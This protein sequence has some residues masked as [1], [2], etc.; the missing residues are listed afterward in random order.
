MQITKSGMVAVVG[1]PN[2]GKS[3]LTNTLAG[4]KVTIVSPKPQTT[5]N[6]ICAVVNRDGTQFVFMDTPG[7]HKAHSALGE[8]MSRVV[9]ESMDGVDAVALMVE[10]VARID[11]PEEL[12]IERIASTGTPALLMINKIDTV[13]AESL[14]EVI[15][16]YSDAHRFDA[17][18]PLCARTGDGAQILLDELEKFVPEGPQLFPDGMVTDQP[19]RVL[20]AEIVREKAL[21][22]LDKEVPHGIA[23]EVETFNE[24]EDGLVEVG[25]TIYCEKE[26]HKGIVIGTNGTML[27]RIGERARADMEKLLGTRVFLETWVKVR[28]NW[29]ANPG[30]VRRFGYE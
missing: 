19:E 17:I 2:V 8:Y 4:E 9:R 10:P 12:L 27:K 21:I 1:R 25:V 30:Q 24:R 26:G 14:L 28:E 16:L 15:A 18:I 20:I 7:F 6:R 22:L 3:T 23:A 5:R 29:R 11:T 13:A